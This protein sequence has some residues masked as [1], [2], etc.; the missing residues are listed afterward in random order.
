[1]TALEMNDV[2]GAQV[3]LEAVPGLQVRCLVTN[4]KTSYGRQRLQI[5]PLNGKGQAWVNLERVTFAEPELD[6]QGGRH[7]LQ[8]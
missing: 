7:G 2:I 4:A 3:F 6:G 5:I 8:S 1:M